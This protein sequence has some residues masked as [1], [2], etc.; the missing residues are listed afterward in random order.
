MGRR[1][2]GREGVRL[3]RGGESEHALTAFCSPSLDLLI[4]CRNEKISSEKNSSTTKTLY[5]ISDS[6]TRTTC[7][8]QHNR[9]QSET[10]A[11]ICLFLASIP[12]TLESQYNSLSTLHL[13]VEE[14]PGPLERR[15]AY[16]VEEFAKSLIVASIHAG[17]KLIPPPEGSLFPQGQI[18]P[19]TRQRNGS[20]RSRRRLPRCRTRLDNRSKVCLFS[21]PST[22]LFTF[23]SELARRVND[24]VALTTYCDRA[25]PPPISI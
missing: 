18:R 11:R 8:S 9:L 23:I 21:S 16:R 5:A 3:R 19:R 10:N 14:S 15:V 6:Q 25:R 7:S 24:T 2:R 13:A 1:R 22:Y 4:S 20:R 12:A 17:P